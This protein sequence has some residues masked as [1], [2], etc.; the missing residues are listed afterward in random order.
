MC[1]YWLQLFQVGLWKGIKADTKA[2]P[3]SSQ[4]LFR[5]K[6]RCTS[7]TR[8]LAF[9]PMKTKKLIPEQT[10][11]EMKMGRVLARQHPQRQQ[12]GTELQRKLQSSCSKYLFKYGKR[13]S[14][15]GVA[16]EDAALPRWKRV[17]RIKESYF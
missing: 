9:L 14:Q 3:D 5:H 8:E 13:F 12:L 1:I 10:N 15:E 11:S 16:V 4:F 6:H 17:Q 7:A 2:S